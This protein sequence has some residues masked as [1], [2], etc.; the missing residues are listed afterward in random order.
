MGYKISSALIFVAQYLPIPNNSVIWYPKDNKPISV[1][2]ALKLIGNR[3][4]PI[5]GDIVCLK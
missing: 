3:L 1:E 2:E 5:Y 4:E